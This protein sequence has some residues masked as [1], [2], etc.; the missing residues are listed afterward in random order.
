MAALV[1]DRRINS[2]SR[3]IERKAVSRQGSSVNRRCLRLFFSVRKQRAIYSKTIFMQL[4]AK[5]SVIEC[6][7]K[8]TLTPASAK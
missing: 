4:Q 8:A 2:H 3:M 5:P 1:F 7:Q 6:R